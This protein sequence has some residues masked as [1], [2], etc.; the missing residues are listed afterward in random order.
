MPPKARIIRKPTTAGSSNTLKSATS[1]AP[2]PVVPSSATQP[3]T[4]SSGTGMTTSSKEGTML[5]P[6]NPSPPKALILEPELDA[7]AICLRVWR[8]ISLIVVPVIVFIINPPER[9]CENKPDTCV[10]C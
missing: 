1:G 7:I 8:F 3:P 2:A 6:P 9:C 10:L 4:T 5:P